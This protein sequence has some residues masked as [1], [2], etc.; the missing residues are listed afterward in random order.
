MLAPLGFKLH[1]ARNAPVFDHL[2]TAIDVF[3]D[4]DA[5]ASRY[6]GSSPFGGE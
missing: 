6:T 4:T 1:S 2:P 3:V 5:T